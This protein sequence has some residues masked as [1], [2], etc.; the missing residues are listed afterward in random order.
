MRKKFFF[1]FL[2]FIMV[3]GCS[4]QLQLRNA[5]QYSESMPYSSKELKIGVTSAATHTQENFVSY[6]VDEMYN[7][8]GCKILYPYAHDEKKPVDFEISLTITVKYSGS[9]TN[10]LISWPGYIVFA[11]A[12]NGFIYFADI[13]TEVLVRDFVNGNVVMSR[14]YDTK[15]RCN[16]SEFDRTFIEI[17]WL[18]WGIIPLIGGFFNTTYDVDITPE[19]NQ[20]I[21]RSYGSYISR[22]IGKYLMNQ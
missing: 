16:Q 9:G 6:V 22:N 2:F 11:P 18:E 1:T 12:W 21:S 10:F 15:Y 5:D 3:G 4:H 19:F 20:A 7:L 14:S 8:P 17:G 13:C